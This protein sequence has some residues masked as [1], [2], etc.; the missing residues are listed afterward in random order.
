MTHDR[1][2]VIRTRE[3][4]KE[5]GLRV[6]H[7]LNANSEMTLVPLSRMAGMQR[8]QTNLGRIPPGKES[9]TPHAH[10]VQEEFIFILEGRGALI[11]GD[12]QV[13]VGP[14]DYVAFPCDGTP[15]NLRNTGTDDL[16]YLMA[17]E[18]TPV[19]LVQLTDAKQLMV[20][21]GDTVRLLDADA[22][23]TMS[24]DQWLAK[25]MAPGDTPSP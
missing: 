14:G 6:R 15:H 24:I 7:P 12:E 9:F 3:L 1:Q 5:A 21:T 16:I 17:G 13:E 10:A 23:E 22:C 25:S 2:T 4:D 11:L 19:E 8:C 20:L 18:T